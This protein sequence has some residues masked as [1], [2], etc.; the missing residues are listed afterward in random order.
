[1]DLMLLGVAHKSQVSAADLAYQ[2]IR[3][4][5]LNGSYSAEDSINQIRVAE[6]LGISRVP[7]RDALQRLQAEGLVTVLP[8]RRAVP[9]RLTLRE[10]DEV[11]QMRAVLEGLCARH[12]LPKISK[13]DLIELDHLVS[14]MERADSPDV[15]VIKHDAFHDLIA[16]RAAMP[17]L[18]HEL[19]S[20][21]EIAIPYIR[22]L[23]SGN[24]DAELHTLPHKALLE[25]IRSADPDIVEKAFCGHVTCAFIEMQE[26]IACLGGGAKSALA[27]GSG[28]GG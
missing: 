14:A 9:T 26:E 11:F 16:E 12:A 23:G 28:K 6:D 17:R 15:Y 8:N 22:I 25:A 27:N 20:L 18:R 4:Q 24:R 3:R 21:R 10:I 1:M 19:A 13:N 5:L 7:V 2:H